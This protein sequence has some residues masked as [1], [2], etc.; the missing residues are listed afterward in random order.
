MIATIHQPCYMPYMGV[1]YK[2]WKSDVLVYLGEAQYTHGE[3]F[4]RNRVKTPQG[5]LWIKVPVE[6]SFGE[7]IDEVSIR[8]YL[9]W[10]KKHLKTIEMNYKKAPFFD[11]V[12]EGISDI[13]GKEQDKL[14]ELNVEIMDWFLEYFGMSPKKIDSRELG[15]NGMS[16]ERVIKICQKVG[17][18]VYI[19]GVNGARYQEKAHFD[20]NGI[21]LVYS[22]YK[23]LEYQQQWGGFIE[24]LSALDFAMNMGRDAGRYFEMMGA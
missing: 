17:A 5:A 6:Y 3:F 8:N 10:R 7:S 4:D 14:G 22:E 12:Y 19:S 21:E 18:E 1:F 23:P 15:D 13:L 16:E 20:E 2:V 24:N 11:E 9:G